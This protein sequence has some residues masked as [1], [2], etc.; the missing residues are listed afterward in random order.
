ISDYTNFS[1]PGLWPTRNSEMIDFILRNP[2]KQQDPRT[3]NFAISKRMYGSRSRC[4]TAQMFFQKTPNGKMH[5]REW[6]SFSPS[7]GVV[8]CIPCKLFSTSVNTFTEGFND[9]KNEARI[10]EHERSFNHRENTRKLVMRGNV[11]GK[12]DSKLH[13]QYM[14]ECNYWRQVLSRIIL[15]IKF[16]ASRGL[17]FRGT[18]EK[19]GSLRNGNYMGVLELMARNDP[20]L[21]NHIDRLGNPGKGNVS[22]FSKDICEEFIAMIYDDL[23]NKL[24]LEVKASQYY[25]ISVDSTPDISHSDQLTFIIRYVCEK[26]KPTERFMQFIP[27]ESHKATYIEQVI[28]QV[29][30]DKSIDIMDCRGQSYDNASNMAGCYGGVQAKIIERNPL[31]IYVPCAAHSLNLVGQAAAECCLEATKFFMFVQHIYTFLS[32]STSRWAKIKSKVENQPGMLLPKSL[33]NTRWSARAEACRAL[34]N[35]WGSLRDALDDIVEDASEKPTTKAEAEGLLQQFGSLETAIMVVVWSDILERFDKTNKSLQRVNIDLTTVV[36]LY[37][38]LH[39]YIVSLRNR[40]DHYEIQAKELSQCNDYARENQRRRRRT[41]KFDEVNDNDVILDTKANMRVNTFL[42]IL[43]R[44]AGELEK[45]SIVYKVVDTRFGFLTCLLFLTDAEIITKCE[46]LQAIYSTDL[47]NDFGEECLYFRNFIREM[48]LTDEDINAQNF[49]LIIREKSIVTIFPNMDI[50]LR[51]YLTLFSSNATGE[52]SFSTLKR[53]KNY[54]RNTMGQSRLSSLAFLSANGE[55]I[56]RAQTDTII[57]KF[58][59]LKARKRQI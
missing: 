13:I 5:Q 33:S 38:A 59:S 42:V 47:G 25:A 49:L 22:Y 4:C 50:A 14:Q 46:E 39:T 1:D 21:Q 45:R 41:A 35:S 37:N 3:M 48:E 19:F 31:A 23:L 30:L 44:L 29:L 53:I 28:V 24:I 57:D 9:W 27:I 43:D 54:L 26:G 15:A 58:A 6:M 56:D 32:A 55:F 34:V 2:L 16:L 36:Q 52:R 18:D 10:A 12:I 20:F 17:A 51:M 40:F 8:F 11:L 7:K